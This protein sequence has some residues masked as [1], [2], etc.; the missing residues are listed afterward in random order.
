MRG[1]KPWFCY[2]V[3][4]GDMQPQGHAQVLLNMVEFG[5]NPQE[6]GEAARVCE[7][8]GRV[9]VESGVSD[10]EI[11]ALRAMGHRVQRA[12]GSFGGYQGILI[13]QKTG[14]Y[15]AASDNRKDGC[16]AGY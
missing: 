12:V 14:V 8:G 10:K 9:L 4:G 7:A 11:E 1:G 2:G 6:A 13:D 16:A 5:M 15:H 3:M